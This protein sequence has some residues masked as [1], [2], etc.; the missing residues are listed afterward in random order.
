MAPNNHPHRSE[1]LIMDAFRNEVIIQVMSWMLGGGVAGLQT[2][3]Y[4][5]QPGCPGQSLHQDNF[6]IQAESGGFASA[7]LALEDVSADN[8]GLCVYPG[9]HVER[10]LDVEPVV[11]AQVA[12]NQDSNAQRLRAVLPPRRY[13]CIDVEVPAG[14]VVFLHGHLLHFSH[15]NSTTDRFRHVLLMTYIRKGQYFRPGRSGREAVDLGP[16]VGR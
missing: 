15:P 9:S 6:Y 10:L 14:S 5:G 13:A 16:E 12:P 2:I 7:W 11:E 4:F 1:P 3:M 8:G